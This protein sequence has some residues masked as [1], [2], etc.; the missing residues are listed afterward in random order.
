MLI[1]IAF[2][3]SFVATLSFGLSSAITQRFATTHTALL[4]IG[5][6]C[7][8]VSIALLALVNLLTS[9]IGLADISII[10]AGTS[11]LAPLSVRKKINEE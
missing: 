5:T 7:A 9:N 2:L 4:L 1:F 10:F 6:I 8:I 3:Y 11:V